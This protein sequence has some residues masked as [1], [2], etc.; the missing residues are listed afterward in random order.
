MPTPKGRASLTTAAGLAKAL[1]VT[2][3]ADH[4]QR[5]RH[6]VLSPEVQ[7]TS[8]QTG[9]ALWSRHHPCLP[10]EEQSGGKPGLL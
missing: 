10:E 5:S 3:I 6:S 4:V 7:H 8:H 9:A 2:I 1:N